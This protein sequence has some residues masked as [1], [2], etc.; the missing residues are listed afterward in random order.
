MVHRSLRAVLAEYYVSGCCAL[1]EDDVFLFQVSVIDDR[2]TI[3]ARAL[4]KVL[5][6][7][8]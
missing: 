3:K 8:G 2:M 6:K 4:R 7:V 1:V 5:R